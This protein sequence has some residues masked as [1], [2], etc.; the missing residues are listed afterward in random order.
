[1]TNQGLWSA[2]QGGRPLAVCLIIAS[3]TCPPVRVVRS[4]RVP[5]A[6]LTSSSPRVAD[7]PL[8]DTW[9]PERVVVLG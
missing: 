7:T 1:M 6:S 8:A 5:P 9:G 3:E 4:R 2:F